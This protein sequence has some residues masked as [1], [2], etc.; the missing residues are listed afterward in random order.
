MEIYFVQ[1]KT[2]TLLNLLKESQDEIITIKIPELKEVNLSSTNNNYI[3]VAQ[4]TSEWQAT[5]VGVI[6]A[7]KLLSLLGFCGN[8][9]F[10]PAWFCIHNKVDESTCKPRKLKKLSKRQQF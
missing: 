1:K 5:R 2:Q 3:D 7:S 6:T 9:E 4:G 10:D 8:K